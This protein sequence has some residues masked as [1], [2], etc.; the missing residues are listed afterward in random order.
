MWTES[1]IKNCKKI[2]LDEIRRCSQNNKAEMLEKA[3]K[4][5]DEMIE[6]AR[7]LDF[8][9]IHD[10]KEV[11]EKMS[12]KLETPPELTAFFKRQLCQWLGPF[13]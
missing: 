12:E 7:N 2:F 5:F 1:E 9:E 13:T 8:S 10:E 3:E 11:I 4:V 6:K